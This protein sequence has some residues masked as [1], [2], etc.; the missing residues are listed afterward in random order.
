MKRVAFLVFNK[1]Q[2]CGWIREKSWGNFSMAPNKKYIFLHISEWRDGS[3]SLKNED[4]G[5]ESR[6]YIVFFCRCT[7]IFMHQVWEKKVFCLPQ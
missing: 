1:A 4:V 7:V 2:L 5:C 3:T 6:H